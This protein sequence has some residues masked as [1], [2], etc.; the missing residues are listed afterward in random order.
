VR[1]NKPIMIASGGK[2]CASPIDGETRFVSSIPITRLPSDVCYQVLPKLFGIQPRRVATHQS[3][4]IAFGSNL[5]H[6]IGYHQRGDA[7]R[8]LQFSMT[9][10]AKAVPGLLP[11]A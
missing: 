7:C 5:M 3:H 11:D 1:C 8:A 6:E 4:C 10:N 2:I 9:S